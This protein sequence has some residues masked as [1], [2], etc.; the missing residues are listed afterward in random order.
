M[1]DITITKRE[2]LVSIAIVCIMLLL[3]FVIAGNISTS[4]ME[5]H[6][7]YNT[8][9][10]VNEDKDLFEYGMRTS[11]GNAFVYGE[12]KAVDPVGYEGVDGDYSYIK[13]VKERYTQ[14]TRVVT[15]TVTVNG[16]PQTRTRIETYW[17]W[18]AIG[19]WEKKSTKLSFLDVEFNYGTIDFPSDSHIT[20]IKESSKIRYVYYGAPAKCTGTIYAQLKDNTI[21]NAQMYHNSTIEETLDSL[22]SSWQLVVFWVFW[23]LL[24]I[25][26]LVGFYCIDN[27]WLEDH[28]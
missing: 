24:I 15:Y 21:H 12:L 28:A 9:L 3:G 19:H 22:T 4:L 18:D 16:K 25:G 8:A 7:E 11:V 2:V 27:W 5:K 6:Q 17:T 14:H 20:T 26:A 23:V 13:K 10:Q 1:S